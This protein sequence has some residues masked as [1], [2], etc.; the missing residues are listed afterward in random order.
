[1]PGQDGLE[2]YELLAPGLIVPGGVTLTMGAGAKLM[3]VS[4]VGVQVDG[5]HLDVLG[6]ETVV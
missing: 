4:G 5:G 2:S 6:T 1:M 3:S